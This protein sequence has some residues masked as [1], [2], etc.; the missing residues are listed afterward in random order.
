MFVGAALQNGKG[1]SLKVRIAN[2]VLGTNHLGR[3]GKV[4]H[5]L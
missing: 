1:A 2:L 4:I 3:V 5:P